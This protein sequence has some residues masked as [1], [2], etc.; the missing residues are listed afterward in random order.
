MSFFKTDHSKAQQGRYMP[1]EGFYEC[2]IQDAKFDITR[3]GTE[4]LHIVLAVRDDV[5]QE[6]Q[7]EFIDWAVWRKKTPTSHDPDG[8]SVGQIQQI[9]RVTGM[10]NGVAFDTIDDWM[11]A[12]RGR[13]IRVEIKHEEYKGNTNAK[14]AYC[15]ESEH[16]AVVVSDQA[17]N[18]FVKVDDEDLPF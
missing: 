5:E 17:N 11:R 18:G 14:V 3:S 4:Y 9:S 6:G 8:F 16:L 15:Y 10:E 13:L 12:L 2:A 7:G 1:P